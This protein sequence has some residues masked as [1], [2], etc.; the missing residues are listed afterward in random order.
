MKDREKYGITGVQDTAK[1][2]LYAHAESKTELKVHK[3]FLDTFFAETE[4]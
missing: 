4:Y 2:R 3:H 1:Y